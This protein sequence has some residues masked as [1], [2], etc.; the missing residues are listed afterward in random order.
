MRWFLPLALLIYI[1]LL[2]HVLHGEGGEVPA[3]AR[4]VDLEVKNDNRRI[5]F[6][7]RLAGAFDENLR[8]KIES[9]VPTGLLYRL[10][11]VRERKGWFD[12][13]VRDSSL[14]MIAMYNAITREYLLNIK[15]D[16][17][18]IDS[19]LIQD[20]RE[21][22]EAMTRFESFHAFAVEPEHVDQKL[23]ARV[24]AELGTNTVFFFIPTTWT[25]DWADARLRNGR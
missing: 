13:R 19:R 23:R 6:S 9:G 3:N 14:Q 7:F 18:L 4:I 10:Q 25:T 24:R 8:R 20:P 2:P 17:N 22:E 12:K 16:G 11:L 1:A 15:H 5:A 21:L